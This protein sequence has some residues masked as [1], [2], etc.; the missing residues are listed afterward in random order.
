[1]LGTLNDKYHIIFFTKTYLMLQYFAPLLCYSFFY[2]PQ[3]KQERK[4]I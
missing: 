3:M 2:F 1:M 4:E